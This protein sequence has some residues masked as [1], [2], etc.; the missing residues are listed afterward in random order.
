[1]SNLSSN[2]P[3]HNFVEKG[4]FY[5]NSYQQY[6]ATT[7]KKVCCL[8]PQIGP[9]E[10]AGSQNLT[11]APNIS[12]YQNYAK[13]ACDLTTVP[14]ATHPEIYDDYNNELDIFNKLYINNL[15]A[16]QNS[17]DLIP[18]YAGTSVTCPTGYI[19]AVLE[20][21]IPDTYQRFARFCST[22]SYLSQISFSDFDYKIYRYKLL[23]SE[24]AC[25]SNV[26]YTPYMSFLGFNLESSPVYSNS[27][28]SNNTIAIVS[29]V[30]GGLLFIFI[31]AILLHYK[32]T[33]K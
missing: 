16:G 29:G 7:G 2:N 12:A 17:S 14:I 22:E 4:N 20:Y 31:L 6:D 24:D 3:F 5:A 8:Y 25:T 13:G 9:M 26:C 30:I 15:G 33:K 10:I 11:S 21:S 27:P 19:P 1:M 28:K 23:N 32:H 18:V